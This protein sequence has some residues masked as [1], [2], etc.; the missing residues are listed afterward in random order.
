MYFF[1]YTVHMD[2]RDTGREQNKESFT[3]IKVK[4]TREP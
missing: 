1:F 4:K 3:S 2:E